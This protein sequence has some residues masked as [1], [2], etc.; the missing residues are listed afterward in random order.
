MQ[1]L[2]D[3]VWSNPRFHES[4]NRLQRA[5]IAKEAK[6]SLDSL[7]DI[8]E[9]AKVVQAAAILACSASPEHREK[10]Y[11]TATSAFE[12]YGASTLPLDQAARVVLARLGNFPAL[13]TREP[14]SS[15]LPDLPVSLATEELEVSQRQTIIFND[16]SVVLTDFQH[17][18]WTKLKAK[19]RLALTA[20]TSTG[21]SFILQNFLA[22]LFEDGEPRTVVYLV[23]TRALIAQVSHDLRKILYQPSSSSVASIEITTVPVEAGAELPTRA[24]YVMTQERLQLMLNSHSVLAADVVIVDEAHSIADGARGVLLQWVIEDLIQRRPEVQ[25]L[26]ASPG[27]RN[28]GVFGRLLGLNDIEPLPSNEPTVAQNFLCLTVR[29]PAKGGATLYLLDKN[30]APVQITEITFER[31]TSTRIEKLVNAAERIGWGASNIVYA[32]GAGDAEHIALALAARFESQE[33]TAQREALAT[34]VQEAVHR[35]YAL[36]ECVRRGVAFHYAHMPT[37]V[38]QAVERAVIEGDI[39]YLVCTSTLLSGVNLPAKNVFMCRPEKGSQV[40]LESVDFWNLAGRAGRLLKEFQGNIFLIDYFDWKKKPLTQ[41]RES[42][43]VPAIESGMLAKREQLLTVIAQAEGRDN[44]LEAV[45]VRL[46]DDLTG[47]SLPIVLERL[48]DGH[49]VL[50]SQ[51]DR[52][53]GALEEA[54]TK[55]TLPRHVLR[56]SANISAH[57]QQRLYNILRRQAQVS[58]DAARTLLPRHPRDENAYDS[59]ARILRICHMVIL[60]RDPKSKFHR[61]IALIA[62]WWMQGWPLPRIVQRRI[63]RDPSKERRFL[64]RETLELVE[65]E[66]RYQCVR[67]FGCYTS[68]LTQVLEDLDMQ[69]ELASMPAVPLFLEIG[70]SDRTMISLMTIGLARPT[71]LK[72]AATAPERNFDVPAALDWLRSVD[73]EAAGLSPL[74]CAEV[75]E[76]VSGL[77]NVVPLR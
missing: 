67:L 18:L 76:V 28:L 70:A 74:L 33:T 35:S 65:S 6:C 24:I 32:N 8:S 13:L 57:R 52:L 49:G 48:R 59:Y 22:S 34:L 40:P 46:L 4:A 63:N 71:A 11:R 12:L 55:V 15:S 69:D 25:L 5:W 75:T 17:R 42:D 30:A 56:K 23:P 41:E 16:R 43:I 14:I 26:F 54:A 68:I 58:Q 9:V 10:A 38:R 73:L 64:V 3:K 21:K 20:P 29:D 19:R 36:V 7:P 39:N 37:Q 77:S 44:E 62:L 53:K 27:V 51:L 31:R 2:A 47:G 50:A 72:L 1:E 45:F 66:V 61:F 60:G